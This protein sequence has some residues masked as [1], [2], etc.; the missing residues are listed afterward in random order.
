VYRQGLDRDIGII[1]AGSVSY[2]YSWDIADST[3]DFSDSTS[4]A[5]NA[6]FKILLGSKSDER[7]PC[8]LQD[9][10]GIVYV[11]DMTG[12][13]NVYKLD[14]N[15]NKTTH[16]TN[17][18]GGAFC[19]SVSS[20]SDIYYA[21]YKAKNYSIYR[22]SLGN[23]LGKSE[24]TVE[25]RNYL[26][27]P[28]RFKIEDHFAITPFNKKR[29]LNA[30]VPIVNIGPSFIGSKFGLNVINVGAEAY[31]SDLLGQ[32]VF[33]LGGSIGKNLKETVPLN[34]RFE[35]YY[36]RKLVPVTSSTYTH[37]PTLFMG[38]SRSV[39]HNHIG[40]SEGVSDSVFFADIPSLGYQNVLCNQIRDNNIAGKY[41]HEFRFFN[42]GINVPLAPRHSLT[43]D[44]SFRQYYETL[45]LRWEEN[46]LS[47]YVAGGKNIT[48]EVLGAGAKRVFNFPFHTDMEYYRSSEFTMDYSYYKMEPSAD[49][50]LSPRGTAILARFRH[51]RTVLADSLVEQINLYIPTGIYNDGSF[52][53]ST[54]VPD[55]FAD[56]YRPLKRN[57]DVNEYILLVQR[58]QGLP[59][60][61]HV[62]AGTVFM[63][64]KDIK[65]KD[66]LKGEGDGYNF[67]LKYYLGGQNILSGYPY[68]SFWGTKFFY[69]RF[70]YIF[71]IRHIRKN[72]MGI[73]FQRLY[74][75][76]FFETGRTWNFDRI[77]MDKLRE[78][79]LKSDVGFELRLNMIS[80]YR[81]QTL[82]TAKIV[83]PLDDM[84]D[85]PYRKYR[86]A[87][88]FY[89]GLQM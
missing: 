18:Y 53:L 82:L 58:N 54:Y 51:S 65:I 46:D 66:Y 24:L 84:D 89:F 31:V 57:K 48:D 61:R 62:F 56:E 42:I 19:P 85:S 7:D 70:D 11:S 29:I 71:P 35:V 79:E 47:T 1:D 6:N 2:R 36:Q 8:F 32:D 63:G 73:H 37:S 74:G 22:T 67:P 72:S 52:E 15:S 87:R 28:E 20:G 50:Y 77:T 9:G 25:E 49:S 76:L 83:W 44:A 60:L 55:S 23:E 33:T 26:Q 34:D 81:L 88:R 10:S 17:L 75:S 78:G 3:S 14:L 39:I 4:F 38:A 64:Y 40:V 68:F 16:L 69:S 30:V 27:Q 21:G 86:D 43:F 80:F 13:F 12:V 59:Y 41:R 45:K 5:E